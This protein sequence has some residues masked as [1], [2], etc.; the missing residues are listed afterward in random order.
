MATYEVKCWDSE[1]RHWV[2]RCANHAEANVY[3]MRMHDA[4]FSVIVVE[5]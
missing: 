2:K 5:R 3:R 1:G 4:G